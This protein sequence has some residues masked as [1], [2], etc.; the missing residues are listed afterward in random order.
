MWI[1]CVPMPVNGLTCMWVS[2][3]LMPVPL[4]S[5]I[6][7]PVGPLLCRWHSA[8][9]LP[10]FKMPSNWADPKLRLLHSLSWFSFVHYAFYLLQYQ[11]N[12]STTHTERERMNEKRRQRIRIVII[13]NLQLLLLHIILKA[14]R[15]KQPVNMA[16]LCA[17]IHTHT[18]AQRDRL[19]ESNQFTIRSNVYN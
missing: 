5:F 14:Y 15:T 3:I 7:W 19:A 13:H 8:F 11:E 18:R 9:C 2:S 10:I 4:E 1:W 16:K 6:Y 17:H 12:A